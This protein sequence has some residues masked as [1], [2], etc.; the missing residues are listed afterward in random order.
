MTTD[1]VTALSELTD[2]EAVRLLKLVGPILFREA[3]VRELVND[4]RPTEESLSELAELQSSVK[5]EAL[6][7]GLSIQL[8]RA[9]LYQLASDSRFAPALSSALDRLQR[10]EL[11]A[12][13]S[14]SRGLATDMIRL[15]GASRE[16]SG[17]MMAAGGSGSDRGDV[18]VDPL[19]MM[20]DAA[21]GRAPLQQ[22][23][24]QQ[25]QAGP[26]GDAA[27]TKRTA[28]PHLH[29]DDAV[30]VDVPFDLEVGLREERDQRLGGM[31]QISLPAASC[32]LQVRLVYDPTAFQMVEGSPQFVLHVTP[33]DPYPRIRVS[34]KALAGED[35]TDERD[36]GVAYSLD[37]VLCGYGSRDVRVVER[38]EDLRTAETPPTFAGIELGQFQSDQ[39]A[40]LTIIV[41]RG[42][43]AGAGRLIFMAISPHIELQMSADLPFENLGARPEKFL[44]HL[45]NTVRTNAK[46]FRLFLAL[47]GL[48]RAHIATKI[49]SSIKDALRDVA[50]H[51]A[52]QPASVL[53]ISDDP[54]VP[55]ELAVIE[56]ALVEGEGERSPF[57]GAQVALGR[58]ILPRGGRPAPH[59][60][61]QLSA[62]ER[63]IIVGNYERIPRFERLENA[64]GE[65]GDLLRAW[66]GWAEK[67]DADFDDVIE[68][69]YGNPAVDIM[70]FA[71]HGQFRL[72]GLQDGLVL[73]EKPEREGAPAGP[74]FLSPA[75]VESCDFSSFAR[76]PFVFLNACQVGAGRELLSDYA[77]MAKA[78]LDAGA[79][80]VVAPLWSINDKDARNVARGLY[81]S[82]WRGSPPAEF[83]RKQRARFTEGAARGKS[84]AQ[85]TPTHLAYQ[86]FGHPKFVLENATEEG[87]TEE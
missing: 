42:D 61:L 19:G 55:W 32:E 1:I 87:G 62:R 56:P 3:E 70:H 33:E 60:R 12:E 16:S 64:E 79:S 68:C 9:I 45:L 10:D 47:K 49:P 38:A 41:K 21:M 73:I 23:Q 36:I 83:L 71:L 40:D 84:L 2:S 44:E 7:S 50:A 54:Y 27:D 86:F 59:P 5:R 63:A 17:P 78:F 58:W 82:A 24:Q 11:A 4:Y 37:G 72:D 8:A 53:I 34:L 85:G 80:A 66:Q 75:Q 28:W 48:G 65:A 35:L 25:Q 67:V 18:A 39:E 52:P 30:V 6:P 29:C 22:Q 46:P 69:L 13:V 77:G 81:A 76:S 31:G 14:M 26:P 20:A 74:A 15:L 43:D 57:L 51:V